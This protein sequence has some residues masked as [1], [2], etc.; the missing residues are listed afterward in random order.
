M[1]MMNLDFL[2]NDYQE[3]KTK[4]QKIEEEI[5]R[6]KKVGVVVQT[7]QKIETLENIV[8]YLLPMAKELKVFNTICAST[9]LRQ[10]E[11]KNSPTFAGS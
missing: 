1:P 6:H 10:A 7:T 5:K 8:N 11:A 3:K 4:A 9:S 2:S